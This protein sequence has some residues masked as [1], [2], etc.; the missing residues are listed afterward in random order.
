VSASVTALISELERSALFGRVEWHAEVD[1]TNTRAVQRAGEP[2]L[3]TPYLIGAEQ[4]TA[5]RG[6][7]GN[8]WWSAEG[9]LLVSV[10][11]DPARDF[12][13]ESLVPAMWPRLSLLSAVCWCDVLEPL[14]PTG[15]V[16]LKWPN[17][18]H[19]GGRK[20]AGILLESPPPVEGVRRRL[21]LGMG[22][23]V[24]N[25]LA[26][27]PPEVAELATSVVDLVGQP[28]DRGKLLVEWMALFRQRGALL[29]HDDPSLA[30]AWRARCVLAGSE[31]TLQSGGHEISGLCLG[32]DDA[33][34]LLIDTP[35]G[36]QRCHGGVL[37]RVR[38]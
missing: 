32:I 35:A 9:A 33:G 5:G 6:R 20:I 37:V 4:Q 34:A 24:N 7:G 15:R 10:V 21:V 12:G 2:D 14:R 19:V 1:S 23:N 3:P 13:G 26:Q 18:V 36:T 27:A 16:G 17:D 22:V 38:R 25:S 30:E 28:G 11:L 29:A 31:V 8:R